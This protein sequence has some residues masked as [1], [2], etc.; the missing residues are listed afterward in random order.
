MNKWGSFVEKQIESK[1]ASLFG[2]SDH[3]DRVHVV[4]F[5]TGGQSKPLIDAINCRN[6]RPP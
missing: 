1:H 6:N 3:R 5:G 4:L 2:S